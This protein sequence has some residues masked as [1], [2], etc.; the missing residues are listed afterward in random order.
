MVDFGSP[1]NS[2]CKIYHVLHYNFVNLK[3]GGTSLVK[4]M[5]RGGVSSEMYNL[6]TKSGE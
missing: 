4:W 5:E 3:A 6:V 1:L 2:A